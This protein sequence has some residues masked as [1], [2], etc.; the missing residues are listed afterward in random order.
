MGS[1]RLKIL[2]IVVYIVFN[3]L[4][5]VSH[6]NFSLG[7]VLDQVLQLSAEHRGRHGVWGGGG[8]SNHRDLIQ[9]KLVNNCCMLTELA[10]R[11]GKE[12]S[13]NMLTHNQITQH[14]HSHMPT[15]CK[16]HL[17]CCQRLIFMFLGCS[18]WLSESTSCRSLF[19]LTAFACLRM[20]ETRSYSCR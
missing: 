11:T 16:V 14:T 18:C 12:G 3:L 5:S 1:Y 2:N 4:I 20:S 6:L 9:R 17:L 15:F 13:K 10:Q 8:E 19:P 7:V